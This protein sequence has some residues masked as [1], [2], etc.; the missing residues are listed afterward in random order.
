MQSVRPVTLETESRWSD[1]TLV[2]AGI[3][4][5]VFAV[6]TA[7]GADVRIP[8]PGTPVPV[9]LQTMFVLLAGATLGPVG[10]GTSLALYLGLRGAGVIGF[11]GGGL[12]VLGGPTAGYLFGFV[13]A[14]TLTGWMAARGPRKTLAWLLVSMGVGSVAVYVCGV[15]WLVSGF[16]L[17]LTDA[18]G[19]GVLPFVLGDLLKTAAAAGLAWMADRQ[20][21]G[22]GR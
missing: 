21:L 9:T 7:L 20:E 11:G 15:A 3:G 12:A 8:I 19:Q 10:G 4:V 18:F 2:E 6:L 13:V 22:D 5:V 16:R 1:R 17:P 14:A